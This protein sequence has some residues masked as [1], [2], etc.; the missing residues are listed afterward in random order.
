MGSDHLVETVVRVDHHGAVAAVA[1]A[2]VPDE[3]L[4]ARGALAGACRGAAARLRGRVV[5]TRAV[6]PRV[7]VTRVAVAVTVALLAG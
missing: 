2:R 3:V 6:S 5:A 7:R 4:L 1:A